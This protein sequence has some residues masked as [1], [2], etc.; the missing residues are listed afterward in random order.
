MLLH[1]VSVNAIE[2]IEAIDAIVGAARCSVA[3]HWISE[4]YPQF[5]NDFLRFPG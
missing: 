2:A 4:I 3:S 1:S 5:P